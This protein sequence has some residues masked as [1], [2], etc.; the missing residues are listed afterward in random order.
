MKV[1][2]Y[3]IGAFDN[4][5]RLE[6][7]AQ[8]IR[9]EQ[10]DI[11]CVQAGMGT[12]SYRTAADFIQESTRIPH[13][14]AG[15]GKEKLSGRQLF[16][17]T[18]TKYDLA[19]DPEF[20]DVKIEDAAL[21]ADVKH[22]PFGKVRLLN[23]LLGQ[24]SESCRKRS[25]S[26]AFKEVDNSKGVNMIVAGCFRSLS[27]ADIYPTCEQ[28]P[29]DFRDRY[30]SGENVNHEVI[31]SLLKMGFIDAT[32]AQD[33]SP[34]DFTSVHAAIRQGTVPTSIVTLYTHPNVRF[35][36]VFSTSGELPMP[37]SGRVVV[38]DLTKIAAEHYPVVAVFPEKIKKWK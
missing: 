1:M 24:G 9:R 19:A 13:Y 5:V 33:P 29:S 8:V 38:N 2:T 31:A 18:F 28:W 37:S 6:R 21:W 27:P 30:L 20:G 10:P 17:I 35:D 16:A 22:T 11:C 23:V 25:W 4:M 3:N 7:I 12:I 14:V 26:T 34:S 36:Y 15:G 32:C